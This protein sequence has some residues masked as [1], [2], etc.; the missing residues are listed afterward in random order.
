FDG[1]MVRW[2]D[3]SMVRW[4]DGSMVRWFD[5]S[6][7][8]WFDGSMVRFF[9]F[10]FSNGKLSIGNFIVKSPVLKKKFIPP[11]QIK[12]LVSVY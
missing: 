6:M 5:G 2:F 1:S 12:K 8:R 9:H 10:N 4:F 3:G 7:V 11:Q